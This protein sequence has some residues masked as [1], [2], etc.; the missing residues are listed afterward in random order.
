MSGMQ[1]NSSLRPEHFDLLSKAAR[2]L[3]DIIPEIEKA[4]LCGVD[5][6][7]FRSGHAYLSDR[8]SKFLSIYFPHGGNPA[9]DPGVPRTGG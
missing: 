8:V 3:H 7:E 9:V 5:C 4:E 2:D 6:Q 1:S